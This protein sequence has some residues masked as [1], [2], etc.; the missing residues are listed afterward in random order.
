MK[1][2]MER[3]LLRPEQASDAYL[4]DDYGKTNPVRVVAIELEEET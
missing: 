2:E 1:L 3:E 4:Y